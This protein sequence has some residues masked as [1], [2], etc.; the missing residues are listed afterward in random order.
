MNAIVT[1]ARRGIGRAI[2]KKFIDN[3]I[4]VWATTSHCD[5]SFVDEMNELQMTADSGGG[6]IPVELDLRSEDSIKSAVKTISSKKDENG[7][8]LSLDIL[9]NNAG[10]PSGGL[11]QM[12]S[13]DTLRDVMEVNFVGQ[14]SLIQKISK[15]MIRESNKEEK[16]TGRARSRSIVNIGSVGGIEAREGYLAYGSSKAAF[17][18]ATRCISKELAPY[19]I[20][21]NAVAP[22]LIDTEMGDFKADEE[23][24]KILDAISMKRKGTPE[25]IAG[26]VY[27][28]ATDSSSFITGSI[29]NAD[30]GRLI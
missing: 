11:M 8:K 6:I 30:G 10:V 17:M 19:N 1:G 21:V 16:V 22:G 7:N 25:E 23:Q 4:N 26:V 15:L 29:I 24:Q 28:L 18:W 2:V 12:T 27:F 3:G 5:D 13:M 20:R 9:V 14:I